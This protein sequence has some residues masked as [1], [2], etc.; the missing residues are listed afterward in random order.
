MKLFIFLSFLAVLVLVQA[1]PNG[2]EIEITFSDLV[3][4]VYEKTK[5]YDNEYPYVNNI[6]GRLGF[7]VSI[8][9]DTSALREKFQIHP[10]EF[11][12][13]KNAQYLKSKVPAGLVMYEQPASKLLYDTIALIDKTRKV[14]MK[15][16]YEEISAE[17]SVQSPDKND[18]EFT[19]GYNIFS[20]NSR[21]KT[22]AER[23]YSKMS[24]M[25]GANAAISHRFTTKI[26]EFEQLD[27]ETKE[28]LENARSKCE[29]MALTGERSYAMDAIEYVSTLNSNQQKLLLLLKQVRD[30]LREYNQKRLLWAEFLIGITPEIGGKRQPV[31]PSK[32]TAEKLGSKLHL[33]KGKGKK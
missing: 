5:G 24:A 7:V 16:L 25:I 8:T 33:G 23:I 18:K 9:N 26:N 27:K 1:V 4:K 3:K 12:T 13:A 31:E 11:T 29:S 17:L 6:N 30:I 2:K 22:Q 15:K 10:D 20:K 19:N 28:V 14:E 21:S 32:S